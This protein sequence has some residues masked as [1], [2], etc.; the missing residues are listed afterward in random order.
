MTSIAGQSLWLIKLKVTVK[1][2]TKVQY[3]SYNELKMTG[4]IPNTFYRHS[5]HEKRRATPEKKNLTIQ[6]PR[7]IR[8]K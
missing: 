4:C 5:S 8:H 2:P 6:L 7:N 1:P 3:F